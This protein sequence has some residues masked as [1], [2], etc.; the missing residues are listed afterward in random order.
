M[1]RP[2]VE[3]VHIVDGVRVRWHYTRTGGVTYRC[4]THGPLTQA[5]CPHALAA[6]VLLAREVL[7]VIATTNPTEIKETHP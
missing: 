6:A 3:A 4:D 5:T 1:S 2:G 7:G